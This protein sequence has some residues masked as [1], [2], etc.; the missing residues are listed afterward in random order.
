MSQRQVQI[1]A[2]VVGAV[3][4]TSCAGA[5]E[6]EPMERFDVKVDDASAICPTVP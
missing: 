6:E 5:G 3:L 1:A 2:M 4:G